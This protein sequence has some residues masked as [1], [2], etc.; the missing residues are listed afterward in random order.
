MNSAEKKVIIVGGVAGGANVAARLRRLDER[1][2]ITI[3]ERGKYVSFANCGLPYHIGK[4]IEK[5]E[6]LLLHTPESLKKRFAIDVRVGSEVVSIDRSAKTVTAKDTTTNQ[7][8]VEPYDILVL[9]P[10]AAPLRPDLPG[11][12][13]PGI[14]TLRDMRD[15]DEIIAA[16]DERPLKNVAIIGG[17][18]IGLEM[19]EQ[20]QARLSHHSP[21]IRLIEAAPHV[22]PPLDSEMAVQIEDELRRNGIKLQLGE[23]VTGFEASGSGLVIQTETG[24][25]YA[26]DLVLLNIGVRPE[27]G[28]AK[29]AGLEIGARGGIKVD[30]E[31]RTSDPAI[32]A[33][34]DCI[35]TKH[36]VTGELGIIPLAGP[37]NRQ[38]RIVA[39]II[40]GKKSEYR[41]TLGTAIVRVF[42]TI[43]AITGPNERTLDR[44]AIPHRAVYLHPS[45]HAGYYP[46]AKPIHLKL[47][48]APDTGK[49]LGAQAVGSDGVDKRIDV[50]ATAITGGLAVEDLTDLELCYAPPF[51]SAKDPV[52]LAGMVAQ[53]VQDGLVEIVSPAS[54]GSELAD[55]VLLDVR[56]NQE[57]AGGFIPNSL[58]IPLPEIRSRISELPKDKN[59]LV[60]CQSG[61]R[62][63]IAC[64]ILSQHGLR[65]KNLTGA[66]KSWTLAEK[67]LKKQ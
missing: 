46:G 35:E 1:C 64:R 3:H 16:L 19:A 49:I 55:S 43:A 40:S 44:L 4:Q 62:S 52:N 7:I 47:L 14:H 51:G 36:L 18:F 12:N 2:R 39:N 67:A 54:T 57:R 53:N 23:P 24:G 34:G 66:Y 32:F 31:L 5:R 13:L 8:S 26:A 27:T 9:S 20:L 21:E 33:V 38:G 30:S 6:K 60:F 48:Y 56:D 50:I 37:A 29:N 15:M 28:L 59:I 61:Q 17:G 22:L 25:R 58:H 10:G 63:Y 65:C 42:E 11:I 45:S 41:G